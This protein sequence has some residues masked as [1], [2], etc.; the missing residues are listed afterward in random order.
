MKCALRRSNGIIVPLL[1]CV[2]LSGCQG[3]AGGRKPPAQP[4]VAVVIEPGEPFGEDLAAR[5]RQDPR[6]KNTRTYRAKPGIPAEERIRRLAEDGFGMVAIGSPGLSGDLTIVA[7]DF[8]STA[9]VIFN[10]V[11][12]G[13]NVASVGFDF[14]DGFILAGAL[15]AISTTL[16]LPGGNADPVVAFIGSADSPDEVENEERIRV[17]ATRVNPRIKVLPFYGQV[18]SGD[19]ISRRNIG[20]L[21]GEAVSSGADVIVLGSP[22]LSS[23]ASGDIGGSTAFFIGSQS[24]VTSSQPGRY[25]AAIIPYPEKAIH[26]IQAEVLKGDFMGSVRWFGVSDGAVG[27]TLLRGLTLSEKRLLETLGPDTRGLVMAR[28]LEYRRSLP[29][30]VGARVRKALAESRSHT[31]EN[32]IR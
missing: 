31:G 30:D 13:D 11:V 16:P 24:D 17:G 12:E 29:P 32:V 18:H 7:P 20:G 8:P 3:W 2:A 10:A 21:I 9:F 6:M 14:R 27:L 5:I 23:I 15:A 22:E 25:L 1:L 26:D 19:Q 4:R 28:I